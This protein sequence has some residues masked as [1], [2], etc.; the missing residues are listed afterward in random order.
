M[1]MAYLSYFYGGEAQSQT[2]E[3]FDFTQGP[4]ALEGLAA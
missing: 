2:D 4:E 1:G 3:P